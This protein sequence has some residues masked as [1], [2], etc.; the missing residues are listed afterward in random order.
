[1]RLLQ[2]Q[3]SAGEGPRS[4]GVNRLARSAAPR[5]LGA[6]QPKKQGAQEM[7]APH[8]L[9]FHPPPDFHLLPG[10]VQAVGKTPSCL[11]HCPRA[12]PPLGTHFLGSPPARWTLLLWLHSQSPRVCTCAPEVCGYLLLGRACPPWPL[13]GHAYTLS[14]EQAGTLNASEALSRLLNV[15]GNELCA[16]RGLGGTGGHRHIARKTN[17]ITSAHHQ[18]RSKLL[19]IPK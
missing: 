13:R 1:M 17:K 6:A 3:P 2:K 4:A 12:P 10:V 9:L 16:K 8:S 11:L 15:E 5:L 19:K 7:A 18:T 14:N